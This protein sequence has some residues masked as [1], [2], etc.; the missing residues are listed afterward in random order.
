MKIE[1]FNSNFLAELFKLATLKQDVCELVCENLEYSHIPAELKGYKHIL[2]G[3]K[4]QW[5]ANM[6]LPSLGVIL[7]DNALDADVHE[8]VD[9]INEAKV[10]DKG[11]ILK[12]FEEYLKRVKFQILFEK[13]VELYNNGKQE[14]AIALNATESPKISNFSIYSVNG[15]VSSIFKDFFLRDGKRFMQANDA[16]LKRG[17]ISF[18]IDLLDAVSGG[19]SD[20]DS[21]E[22][23]LF[24]GRSGSGKTKWLRWRGI[25]A[26][27]MGRKVLH[28]QLEGTQEECELGY[29]ATWTSILKKALKT[30]EIPVEL[31]DK[32]KKAIK[33]IIKMGGE[34]E[35]IAFEQFGSVSMRDIREKV[36]DFHKRH[37]C[38]PDMLILDYLELAEPGNGKHYSTTTEGEK[39]RREDNARAFKNICNEFKMVGAT[40]SQA[41][42]ISPADYNNSNWVMTRHNV[43]SA[44]GLVDSFSYFVTWNV[45]NDEYKK[46]QGRLYVDKMREYEA[47]QTIRI[48]TDF[49]HDRFYSRRETLDTWPEDYAKT[50]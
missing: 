7:Q 10:G 36:L 50:K 39:Y 35:V 8:A 11:L 12:A 3:M 47:G 26:A 6:K 4:R 22:T 48:C 28:I 49:N 34:I 5:G 17:K 2:K 37:G 1:Q 23:D 40:A 13:T 45:S 16:T 14:E 41:N 42:D 44:K 46:H 30:G 31:E 33:D 29:D 9:Q 24:L 21:G 43:S 18:G 27:R 20:P 19:G 25:S 15:G 38:Y 32:L